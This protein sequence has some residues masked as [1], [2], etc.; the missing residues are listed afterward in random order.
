MAD[1]GVELLRHNLWANLK[2]IDACSQMSDAQLDASATGTYGTARD[3][4]VHLVASEGRYASQFIATG[5]NRWEEEPFPGFGVL[6]ERAKTSGQAL[7]DVA[8]SNPA[9][10]RLKG[11]YRDQ[12]Y[13]IDASIMLLQAINH[14]TEHRSH[15]IGILTQNGVDASDLRTDGFIYWQSGANA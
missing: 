10:R 1:V 7:L 11:T 14:A 4:L 3:T 2:L 15:I 13:E 8:S 12:P 6:G 9:E 5:V